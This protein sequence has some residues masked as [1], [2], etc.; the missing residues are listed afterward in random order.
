M[1][2]L[3]SLIKDNIVATS[4]LIV[5]LWCVGIMFVTSFFTSQVQFIV[6]APIV[7]TMAAGLVG[8]FLL[9]LSIFVAN[10]LDYLFEDG[11]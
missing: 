10:F 5:V 4:I 2:F 8:G 9:C 1:K 7:A 3:Y 11:Q 6:T